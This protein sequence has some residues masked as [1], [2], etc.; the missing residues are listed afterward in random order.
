MAQAKEDPKD[1]EV[2]TS[3]AVTVARDAAKTVMVGGQA[4]EVVK[5]V[6]V[7]TLKQDTGETVAFRIDQPI[8]E[9][10]NYITEEVTVNGVKQNATRE[11]IINIARVTEAN[12]MQEFE[13]VC[14]AMTAD[15]LRNTYPDH[16]YVGKWFAILKLGVVA[17]KRYKETRVV[18][19]QPAAKVVDNA[20]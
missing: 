8:R 5:Q 10:T 7:P 11:N 17:G 20:A 14:N 4:F 18:E 16:G 19:L 2:L 12:S 15:N 6:N 3:K 9:E 13:Y 1:G